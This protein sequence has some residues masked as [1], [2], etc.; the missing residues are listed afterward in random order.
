M[1]DIDKYVRQSNQ[2]IIKTNGS[3]DL[4]DP[5]TKLYDNL[6]II[7]GRTTAFADILSKL[8]ITHVVSIGRTPHQ[9]VIMGPFL[10]F[11]L[12]GLLDT[13]QEN[14]SVH[15]PAIFDFIRKAI[16]DGGKIA[17][18][19][20]MGCSRS[21]TVMIAFLRASGYFDSLQETYDYVKSKRPWIMPNNG[22]QEQLRKFF[23]EKLICH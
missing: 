8:G 17:C 20:E 12:Q 3:T 18:G 10:K 7:Q 9:A 4:V 23:S 16:K 22:F 19:C 2:L 13:P 1:D 21:V 15:F 5:I 14:L 6:F 11:E